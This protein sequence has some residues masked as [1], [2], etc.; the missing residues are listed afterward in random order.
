[1]ASKKENVLPRVS[2]QRPEEFSLTLRLE[3]SLSFVCFS[4]FVLGKS[5]LKA[6]PPLVKYA[7]LLNFAVELDRKK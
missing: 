4:P 1:M 7:F 2:R 6:V 3:L 5:A